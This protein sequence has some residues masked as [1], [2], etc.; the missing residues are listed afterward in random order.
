MTPGK[1]EG[2]LDAAYRV[3]FEQKPFQPL[4]ARRRRLFAEVGCAD[5][6]R[7]TRAVNMS[8]HSRGSGNQRS[9]TSGLGVLG[10][11]L[12]TTTG[13]IQLV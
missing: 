7:S 9:P 12:W 6:R 11:R 5:T 8:W 13:P 3:S 2:V 1:A 10:V 4:D